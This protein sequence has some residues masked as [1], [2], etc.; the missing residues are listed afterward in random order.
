[1]FAALE[2]Y[3]RRLHRKLNRSEWAIRHLGLTSSEGTAE[4]SGLL[5]I[6]IDGFSRRQFEEALAKGRM[7]FLARLRRRG[8]YSLHTFYPGIPSTTP[9]VQAELYYGAHSAV[10][11]FS[12]Y[13]R[14]RRELGV[15]YNS[16]WAKGVESRLQESA[17]GLLKGG[18]SWSNIYT[19]GAGQQESHFCAA[20]I[21]FG[22]MWR[23]GKISNIFIFI[24]LHLAS[25]VRIAGLLLLELAIAIPAAIR[26]IV[27]GQWI[28][29]ELTMVASRTFVGIG[30]RELVSIGA[31]VDVARGLPIVHVNFLG[32]DE[33]SHRRGPASPFAHWSLK[34]IDR[35]IKGLYRSA[36]RST[37]RDY[38]VWI[39]SDHG[40]ERTRSFATEFPG[41]VEQT[42]ATCLE[43]SRTHDAAWRVRP[44]SRPQS[45]YFSRKH[46]SSPSQQERDRS[47]FQLSEEENLTFSVAAM[48]PVGHVY[49]AHPM[50]D[51]HKQA[52]AKRLVHDGKIPGVLHRTADGIITWY[53]REGETSLPEGAAER[54]P[55]HP[56]PLRK[57]IAQDLVSFCETPNAGDLILLG[58]SHD[59]RPWTFAPER[60]AH[61]GPGPEET[62]GFLLVPPATRLP[63]GAADFV[64]PEGLRAAALDLLGRATMEESMSAA[65]GG[66]ASL[67]VMTYNTHNCGGMDGRVSPRRIARV[68]QREN[69]D[70]VALQELDHGR[71]RSR[72]E[73]QATLIAKL[74]G[75]HVVYC[76]TVIRGDDRYGHAVLSRWPIEVVKTGALPAD[77]KSWLQEA[78]G[79]LWTRVLIANTSIN[80][81]TTHLG[82]GVRER[83]LQMEALLGKDW[84]EPVID[85]EAVILCGDFNL[86]PGSAPYGLAARKL[87][88]VQAARKGHRP[89]STFSSLQPFT[90][91]DHIFISKHFETQKVVVPRTEL[92]RLAS[93]HLPLVADLALPSA[94]A[95]TPKHTPPSR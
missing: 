29:P 81:V 15:M 46:H 3:A 14:T 80:V 16:E 52:L 78:R 12:F 36:H 34:G 92:T 17:E 19:G 79:A 4:E 26:G 7:P 38:Q 88:D 64:R 82:L 20:S 69:P 25:A 59:E 91:I 72:L 85:R 89:L 68:I 10:P 66:G 13:D 83:Y 24:C 67:R 95:E 51:E 70:I 84:L 74:L 44:Q 32:Y 28:K 65:A 63:P 73:D 53:H 76:P 6:Q 62:Q 48:G 31:K 30:L 42:I 27:R 71:H 94:I 87:R 40:Q 33:L 55:A 35:A 75:Y 56:E 21:G 8:R 22:D 41:G 39:F 60:G 45:R 18:S 37:R 47:G 90:R 9:A 61:A 58:W 2:A 93:D 50:D 11:A 49:F 54:L 43:L 5:L 23:T 1:M 86:M 77:P 57:E